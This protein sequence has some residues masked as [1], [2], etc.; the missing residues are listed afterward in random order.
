MTKQQPQ[1]IYLYTQFERLWHWLQALMVLCLLVTG[2]EIHGTFI[3]LGFEKALALH[4]FMGISWLVLFAF[5]VFWLFTTGEWK[6]YTPTAKKLLAVVRY[7]SIDIFRGKKHPIPKT[8][9]KFNPLQRLTYLGLTTV[10][11]PV[12]MITGVLLY[13]YNDLNGLFSLS[14]LAGLHTLTA[15]LILAFVIV[16]LYMVTTG[17]T[18][19]THITAMFTG[20]EKVDN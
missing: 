14:A 11:L 15:L 8:E 20:W 7:Y 16:H 18:V 2:F 10:L 1:K 4:N 19:L 13:F 9:A 12:Q 6:Q 17:H 5:F 3:L